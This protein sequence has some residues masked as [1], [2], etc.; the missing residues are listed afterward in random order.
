MGVDPHIA[1]TNTKGLNPPPF[2]NTPSKVLTTHLYNPALPT[3]H[4]AFPNIVVAWHVP[5]QQMKKQTREKTLF[6]FTSLCNSN[7]LMF[8]GSRS[9][10]LFRA[11]LQRGISTPYD[12]TWDFGP[13]F[14]MSPDFDEAKERARG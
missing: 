8:H 9:W 12:T 14:Y 7:N 10:A 6:E 5:L 13:G 4:D 1:T 2:S 3:K 11:F